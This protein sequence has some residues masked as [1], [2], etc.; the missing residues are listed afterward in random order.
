MWCYAD[1]DHW[2]AGRIDLDE[3][4]VH[5]AVQVMRVR[6]GEDLHVLDGRGRWARGILNIE[7]RRQAHVEP[8]EVHLQPPSPLASV[9]LAAALCK[10]ARWEW[11][12]EKVTELGLGRLL[13]MVT[14][15]CVARPSAGKTKDKL[16][17]WTATC[18]R[19]CKQ[20]HNA[21]I[22]EI[23]G[24]L[25]LSD[26]TADEADLRLAGAITADAVPLG[27][28]LPKCPLNE[29]RVSVAIGPEGDFSTMEYE[30]MRGN[31]VHMVSFGGLILRCETASLYVLNALRYEIERQDHE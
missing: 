5:H 2:T 12:L 10:P 31:G 24:L 1:P 14:E 15:H 30:Q 3:S 27:R 21:W 19:A 20:S 8:Q 25:S 4:E 22:P 16:E 28:V 18:I 26:W 23:P 9:T 29:R 11:M 13:P 7:G 6:A 17:K